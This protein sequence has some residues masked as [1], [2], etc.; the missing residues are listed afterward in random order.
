VSDELFADVRTFPDYHR[1]PERAPGSFDEELALRAMASR[2][3]R[4]EARYLEKLATKYRVS[5]IPGLDSPFNAS[6]IS[7]PRTIPDTPPPMPIPESRPAGLVSG[8]SKEGPPPN[9]FN[10]PSV[11]SAPETTEKSVIPL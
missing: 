10:Q 3:R 8:L 7:I 4:R 5:E 9:L 1:I 2:I 6:V 11:E